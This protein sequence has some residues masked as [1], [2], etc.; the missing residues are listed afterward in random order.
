[1]NIPTIAYSQIVRDVTIDYYGSPNEPLLEPLT[2]AQVF[3]VANN[4]DHWIL[5]EYELS[6]LVKKYPKLKN[7]QFI[8]DVKEMSNRFGKQIITATV[9]NWKEGNSFLGREGEWI[10]GPTQ[11]G[12]W[13]PEREYGTG[14][15]SGQGNTLFMGNEM[16]VIF[17]RPHTF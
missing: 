17:R 5:G 10:T 6:V 2:Q 3:T 1:M 13:D 9:A 8:V 15:L 7:Y 4:A 16:Y 11:L 12:V 14:I